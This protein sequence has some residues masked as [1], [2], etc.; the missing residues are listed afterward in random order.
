MC[1]YVV[2]YINVCLCGLLYKCV[3]MLDCYIR[4]DCCLSFS[5]HV[6]FQTHIPKVVGG[7]RLK[8]FPRTYFFENSTTFDLISENYPFVNSSSSRLALEVLLIH[9][10]NVQNGSVTVLK[11]L[12]DEYT[13]SVFSSYTYQT[14]GSQFNETRVGYMQWKPISYQDSSRKSTSSQQLHIVSADTPEAIDCKVEEIPAGL[15]SSL[16]GTN[17]DHVSN[18]THWFVVFGTDGDATYLSPSYNTWLVDDLFFNFL[19]V[20]LS[21]HQRVVSRNTR[22]TV[23]T[24]KLLALKHLWKEISQDSPWYSWT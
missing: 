14:S 20:C 11:S 5:S 12:D 10:E 9:G 6:L 18:V 8:Y 24:S 3:L 7:D 13:P 23:P 21:C 15:A 4:N 19:H 16:Y 17:F 2:C 1:A 22:N